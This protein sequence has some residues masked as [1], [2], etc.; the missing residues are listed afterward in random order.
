M[1]VQMHRAGRKGRHQVIGWQQFDKN[2][3]KLINAIDDKPIE[4]A[5]FEDAETLRD[6]IKAVAPGG[7]TGNLRKGIVAKKFKTKRKGAPATHVSIDY[8]IAPH[9]HLV[10]FGHGG[11]HPAPP[12]PFFRKTV[13]AFRKAFH[14]ESELAKL[15]KRNLA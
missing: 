10:E 15:F 13:R 2:I 3:N 5:L 6:R 12:H 8:R 11:P 14:L 9:A 7:P 1:P 4:D